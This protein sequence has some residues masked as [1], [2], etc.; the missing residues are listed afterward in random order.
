MLRENPKQ[1]AHGR[2]W[3]RRIYSYLQYE[4]LYAVKFI[5]CR[6]LSPLSLRD[7]PHAFLRCHV[8]KAQ[9]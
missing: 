1:G 8:G 4:H 9:I 2:T 7:I 3:C 6:S 5:L